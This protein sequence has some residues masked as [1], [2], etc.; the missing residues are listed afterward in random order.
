METYCS[1]VCSCGEDL[2]AALLAALEAKET[3]DTM[4]DGGIDGIAL[5]D[6][7]TGKKYRVY[8]SN[9]KLTMEEV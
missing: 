8:V 9:G 5:K 3:L 7:T 4:K 6:Q 2:D 1:K